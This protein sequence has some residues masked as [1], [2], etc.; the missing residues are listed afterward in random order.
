MRR[1]TSPWDGWLFAAGGLCLVLF[2]M[3]LLWLNWAG[4][5]EHE[6]RTTWTQTEGL[7]QE[8]GIDYFAASRASNFTMTARY[9]YH[10]EGRT[11]EGTW[12]D[13]GHWSSYLDGVKMLVADFAP[14]AANLTSGDFSFL[15][16]RKTWHLPFPGVR[17][18]VR[19]APG[20]PTR[21]V[22]ILKDP[23]PS[24]TA[25]PAVI[26]GISLLLLL[27]GLLGIGLFLSGF[28]LFT[29]N[30]SQES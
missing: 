29:S 3:G 22:M 13:G 11:Y 21:A 26:W 7:L 16:S 6:A 4:S 12:I 17:V 18:P 14:P 24:G 28:F 23:L 19:Y 15:N 30:P 20:D 2:G 9:T 10:V 5:A 25:H 8:V 27:L 1:S